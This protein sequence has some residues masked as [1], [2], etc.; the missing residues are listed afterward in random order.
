[1]IPALASLLLALT[2]QPLSVM[3]WNICGGTNGNCPLYRAGVYEQAW[4]IA[5]HAEGQDLIFLQEFCTG[6]T[7]PLEKAL[8]EHSGRTWT[9]KA[10]AMSYAD[11]RPHACHP[12]YQGRARGVQ[13][14]AV[15]VADHETSFRV[16][17]LPSPPWFVKRAVLCA[18]VPAVKLHACGTHL[19][20]GMAGDDHQPGRPY[21]MKQLE[22][23]REVAVKPGYRNVF[24]G[25]L[26]LQGVQA[27]GFRRCH[28]VTYKDR[29]IDYLFAGSMRS[30]R[31]GPRQA[32]SDHRPLYLKEER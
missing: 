17:H 7:E 29:K 15:A 24:G 31:V 22:R 30:C 28:G 3:T 23:F 16:H 20:S 13:G 4:T 2:P 10:W 26:N 19:S 18:T 14:I 21:R 12:D 8:E 1:M 27:A 6:A 9:V 5:H 25:D 11:G 32:P